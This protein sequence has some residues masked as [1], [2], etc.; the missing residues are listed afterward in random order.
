V[1]VLGIIFLLLGILSIF[2]N[3]RGAE[4]YAE[5]QKGWGLERPR[6]I[7][8]GRLIGIFGGG[9]FVALG[10]FLILK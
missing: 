7:L 9:M 5:F 1:K 10:L 4:S 6:A 8:V 3:K 2:Y